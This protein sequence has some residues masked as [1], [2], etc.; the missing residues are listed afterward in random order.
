MGRG[1]HFAV[2]C[3]HGIRLTDQQVAELE[4]RPWRA[5]ITEHENW[6]ELQKGHAGPHHSLAQS[7]EAGDHWI[8]WTDTAFG[9]VVLP[10]CPAKGR[11]EDDIED[12]CCLLF[13][14]HEGTHIYEFEDI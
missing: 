6:C 8:R 14:G 13:E 7:D 3:P 9:T 11:A 2:P 5:H 10:I 12:T 1:L 4:S